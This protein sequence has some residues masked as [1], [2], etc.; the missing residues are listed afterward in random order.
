[1]HIILSPNYN[2]F[3][4]ILNSFYGQVFLVYYYFRDKNLVELY[5]ITLFRTLLWDNRSTHI[6]ICIKKVLFRA[7]TQLIR[8]TTFRPIKPRKDRY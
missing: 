4:L 2:I 3:F 6:C 1:M 7:T 8:N 5:K